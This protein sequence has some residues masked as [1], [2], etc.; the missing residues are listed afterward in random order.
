MT[1]T[2][3]KLLCLVRTMTAVTWVVNLGV[4]NDCQ[5]YWKNMSQYWWQEHVYASCIIAICVSFFMFPLKVNVAVDRF[6][7][8]C[9]EHQ[10]FSRSRKSLTFT[11]NNDPT[12]RLEQLTLCPNVRC[13]DK[14]A[15]KEIK[16]L[17]TG[18]S[19]GQTRRQIPRIIK[20][21]EFYVKDKLACK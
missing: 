6:T 3:S 16:L 20:Q 5:P 14:A 2:I 19:Y 7:Y 1:S 13:R 8:F 17:Y 4:L 21:H 11:K 9:S 12:V 10:H 18:H 15:F